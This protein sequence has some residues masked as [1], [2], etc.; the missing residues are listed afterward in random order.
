MRLWTIHPKHLDAQGLVALW[1]EAL[2]ARAVLRGE[3][4]GYRHHPQLQRFRAHSAPRT[5][6]NA[7]LAAVLEESQMRGYSFNATK[8]GPVRGRIELPATAGQ[9]AYEWRHLLDK[10]QA[11]SPDIFAQARAISKPQ[12]HPVFRV[13]AGGV[14]DW[15]R[16]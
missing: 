8:V 3:T 9:I 2:L 6:I 14:A 7:Y 11:R 4:V 12:A 10:L 1:R 13:V 5:A 16:T 15:E